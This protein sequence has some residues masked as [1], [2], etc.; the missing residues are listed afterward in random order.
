M[1]GIT[2]VNTLIRT[3][4]GYFIAQ[5]GAEMLREYIPKQVHIERVSYTSLKDPFLYINLIIT[6]INIKTY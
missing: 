2:T 6:G 1:I 4:G 5:L 3:V